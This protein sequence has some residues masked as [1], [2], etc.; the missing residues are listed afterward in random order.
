MPQPDSGP[1]ETRS[2]LAEVKAAA[3]RA[4]FARR[5]AAHAAGHPAPAARLP[6]LKSIPVKKPPGP[7][8]AVVVFT[9]AALAGIEG[10]APTDEVRFQGWMPLAD[11]RGHTYWWGTVAGYTT[12]AFAQRDSAGSRNCQ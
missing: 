8:L 6:P 4:A 7:P 9:A 3:R 1:P 2:A 5:K 10:T 12:Q 11:S